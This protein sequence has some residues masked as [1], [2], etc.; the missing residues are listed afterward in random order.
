MLIMTRSPIATTVV[1]VEAASNDGMPV[2][3]K[4]TMNPTFTTEKTIYA[5]R[6]LCIRQKMQAMFDVAR[7]NASSDFL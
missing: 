6:L 4:W 3:P 7:K 1:I 2:K 5:D